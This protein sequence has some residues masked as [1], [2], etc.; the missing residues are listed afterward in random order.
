MTYCE[1]T[2]DGTLDLNFGGNSDDIERELG[3]ALSIYREIVLKAYGE[4]EGLKKFQDIVGYHKRPELKG[5]LE[6]V[7]AEMSC[8]EK[9][10]TAT[11]NVPIS[12]KE[13]N[14]D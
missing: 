3:Y 4:E 12:R 9:T 11:W 10:I 1:L 5:T 14:N 8:D 2:P 6:S 13:M 7:K